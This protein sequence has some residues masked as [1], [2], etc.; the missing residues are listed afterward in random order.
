MREYFKKE[1]EQ[2]KEVANEIKNGKSTETE[3]KV[4]PGAADES[5]PR[6]VKR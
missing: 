2:G 5:K 1:F 3:A 6:S 4:E